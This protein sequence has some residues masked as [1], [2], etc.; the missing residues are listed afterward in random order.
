VDRGSELGK[1]KLPWFEIIKGHACYT[2]GKVRGQKG[3]QDQQVGI[4]D[5][6]ADG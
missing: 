3:W 1:K 2:P 6:A 5:G 4:P